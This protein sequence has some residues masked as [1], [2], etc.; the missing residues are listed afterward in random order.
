MGLVKSYWLQAN[1]VPLG[2]G[3]AIE[4]IEEKFADLVEEV[5]PVADKIVGSLEQEPG[6]EYWAMNLMY[7]ACA[8]MWIHFLW[9]L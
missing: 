8:Y 1:L 5:K 3:M 7:D 6:A 2:E 9:L 4:W